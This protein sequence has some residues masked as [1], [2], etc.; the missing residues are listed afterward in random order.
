MPDAPIDTL[1]LASQELLDNTVPEPQMLLENLTLFGAVYFLQQTN[2]YVIRH[3]AG[4]LLDDP[5]A[6][7][8][9]DTSDIVRVLEAITQ[10]CGLVNGA[11]D[12]L[13]FSSEI[14]GGAS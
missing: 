7:T 3:V 8:T 5:D 2:D 14:S 1:A 11:C 9:D 6:D 10:A 12:I 13:G 4:L